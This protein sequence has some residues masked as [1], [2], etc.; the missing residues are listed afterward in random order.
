[1]DKLYIVAVAIILAGVAI[2]AI[3]LLGSAPSVSGGGG[4][5]ILIGPIPIFIG[6]GTS[7]DIVLAVALVMAALAVIALLARRR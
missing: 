1:M 3:G 6:G 5:L 4:I 7:P 2:T